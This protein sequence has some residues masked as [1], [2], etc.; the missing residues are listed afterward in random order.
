M[1]S[2]SLYYY[3]VFDLDR[4]MLV[5]LLSM[6]FCWEQLNLLNDLGRH[7][8][9]RRSPAD[10]GEETFS[11]GI[12]NYSIYYPLLLVRQEIVYCLPKLGDSA[13]GGSRKSPSGEVLP[14]AV[15]GERIFCQES[16][17]STSTQSQGGGKQR[18]G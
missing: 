2:F 5:N 16:E 14:P 8:L 13:R 1:L 17:D 3:V 9:V 12:T 15:R 7:Y 6:S 10:S 18:I 4:S 11:L